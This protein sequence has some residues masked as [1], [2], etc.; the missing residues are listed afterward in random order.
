MNATSSLLTAIVLAAALGAAAPVP[1]AQGETSILGY[2]GSSSFWIDVPDG[3]TS[4]P[5]TASRQKSIFVLMPVGST[6]DAARALIIGSPYANLSVAEALEKV[7]ASIISRDPAAE[8]TALPALEVGKTRF[9]LLE[10]RSSAS[11]SQP[12]Q[13][14]AF[15]PLQNNVAVIALSA[16]AEEPHRQGRGVL[17]DM[18]RSLA[19]PP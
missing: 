5:Q 7:K 13:T 9:S 1:A 16:R 12:F 15:L 2:V 10:I 4:D 19:N 17:M 6:F 3:W 18:L 14:I 11:S 8:I